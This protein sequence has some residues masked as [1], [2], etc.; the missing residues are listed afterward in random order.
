[1]LGSLPRNVR[2]NSAINIMIGFCFYNNIQR[3]VIPFLN[4]FLSFTIP[5][6]YM[7]QDKSICFHSE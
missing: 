5:S 3:G 1:M 6:N 7:L 4:C 2:G